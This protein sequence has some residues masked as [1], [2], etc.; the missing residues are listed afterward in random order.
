MQ[1]TFET[2]QL[3]PAFEAALRHRVCSVCIDCNVDGT[4]D[5]DALHECT[6]F[7]RLPE[8]AQSIS[9]VHSD[10]ADDYVRALEQSVCASC[11]HQDKEGFCKEREEVRCALARYLGPIV[12]TIEEIRSVLLTPGRLL[13]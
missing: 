1:Q 2:Y 7:N 4:C 13:A 5:R 8:I 3:L 11:T 12:E 10:R 9:E 6:L